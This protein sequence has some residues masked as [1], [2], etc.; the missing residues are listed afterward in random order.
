M[1]NDSIYLRPI[2][3]D[4]TKNIVKWRNNPKVKSRFVFQDD[5]TEEMHNNYMKTRVETGEVIQF[6]IV[7]KENDKDI[8]TCFIKDVNYELRCGETGIFLGEE[9]MN[10]GLGFV[11]AH[12]L[13]NYLWD[14]LDFNYMYARVRKDNRNSLRV[15]LH[16]GY[17]I[18]P[19]PENYG[20]PDHDNP[21]VVYLIFRN[22][23]K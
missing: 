11:A 15:S 16:Q 10:T 7:L 17:E 9:Y 20:I 3:Y 13:D 21:D 6:I 19:D 2:S 8:G 5:L 4:D 1:D 18:V 22:P 14:V 23:R 12:A